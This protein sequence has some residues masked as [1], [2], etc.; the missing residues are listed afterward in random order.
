MSLDESTPATETMG[1]HASRGFTCSQA[2]RIPELLTVK[3]TRVQELLQLLGAAES[4]S[5]PVGLESMLQGAHLTAPAAAEHAG[6][7]THGFK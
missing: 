2:K 7:Q 4:G 5:T 6:T 1:L 3:G